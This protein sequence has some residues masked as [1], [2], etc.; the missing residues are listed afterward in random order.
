MGNTISKYL[1]N[2]VNL[3][4]RTAAENWLEVFFCS[5]TTR[6]RILLPPRNTPFVKWFSSFCLTRPILQFWHPAITGCSMPWR[7]LFVGGDL[8]RFSSWQLPST[9][10]EVM[11]RKSGLLPAYRSFHWDGLNV[12]NWR[13]T[14]LNLIWIPIKINA[15]YWYFKFKIVINFRLTLVF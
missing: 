10:A 7:N 6:V 2:C 1:K 3:L 13:G 8:R 14:M 12:F 9:S 5:T 4:R 11:H 15:H